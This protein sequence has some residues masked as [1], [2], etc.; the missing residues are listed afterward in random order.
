MI[1]GIGVDL[2]SISRLKSA[3]DRSGRAFID[4][5]FT[6]GE[7][8]YAQAH[9][10]AERPFASRFAAKEATIKALGGWAPQMT[11]RDMEVVRGHEGPPVLVLHGSARARA[12]E[13][14]IRAIHLSLSHEGDLAIAMVVLES[15]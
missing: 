15:G 9:R 10:E 4:R 12:D 3:I 11:W 13:L 7:Q 14:G 2:A 6:A 1:I 8:A 5:L